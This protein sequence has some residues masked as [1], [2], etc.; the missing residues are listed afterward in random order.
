MKDVSLQDMM[1]FA[2]LLLRLQEVIRAIHIPGR[3]AKE[4]DVEHSYHLAMMGWYI[5][6]KADL[7]YNTDRLIRYAL[8]HDLAEAYAGD[9]SALDLAARVG[10]QEREAR[11]LDRI[12]NEFPAATSII[13]SV[14]SYEGLADD[15]AKFV[16]ALD[17]LMPMVMI[18]LDNGRTWRQDGQEF[19][20]MHHCQ[21]PKIAM[22]RPV[23]QLY[24]QLRHL[25]LRQP[26]LFSA[27]LSA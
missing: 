9:V 24:R 12:E 5:N 7:G 3:D 6:T 20:H 11:A 8:I 18:Y 13:D 16:Y 2:Q 17:K 1:Q 25:L 4:N 26:Q 23:N 10:K 19:R 27:T 21:A 22:S 14:K 15:E